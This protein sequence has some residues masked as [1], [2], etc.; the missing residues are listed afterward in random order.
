MVFWSRERERMH[1]WIFVKSILL[2]ISI[3]AENHHWVY[4]ETEVLDSLVLIRVVTSH[5]HGAF[6]VIIY[7]TGMS[8][9]KFF[10]C[11][12][13]HH[14]QLSLS[15]PNCV[16][17]EDCNEKTLIKKKVEYKCRNMQKTI[18]PIITTKN[19]RVESHLFA[20]LLWRLGFGCVWLGRLGFWSSR[21]W[22]L[23]LGGLGFCVHILR[24]DTLSVVGIIK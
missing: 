11:K 23:N 18:H 20:V 22:C 6:L 7:E 12:S 21:G 14:S 3:H 2:T 5:L 4:F 13:S 10:F 19:H 24:I 8:Q 17:G 15:S 9:S 1:R 16:Q